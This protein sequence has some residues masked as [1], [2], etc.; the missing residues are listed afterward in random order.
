MWESDISGDTNFRDLNYFN[1][2]SAIGE[3]WHQPYYD[4]LL[5]VIAEWCEKANSLSIGY[6]MQN[7]FITHDDWH[8]V[9][10]W[11]DVV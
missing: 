10:A 4:S 11:A 1:S 7:E 2:S 3:I 6:F 9:T 8:M 5:I